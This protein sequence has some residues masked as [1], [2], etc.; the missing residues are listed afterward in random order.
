MSAATENLIPAT[1]LDM[2]EVRI[3]PGWA[4]RIPVSL[5]RRKN[6]LPCCRIGDRVLVACA[7][8]GDVATLDTVERHLEHSIE[9]VQADEDSLEAV[10]R[11]TFGG[12]ATHTGTIRVAAGRGDGD[13]DAVQICEEILQAAALRDASDIHIDPMSQ[14]V[15][16]RL[17]VDGQLEDY[18]EFSSQLHPQISSRIKVLADLDI[19]ERRS[20]QD[21]RFSWTSARGESVDVRVATLPTRFGES[22]TLRLLASNMEDLTLARLGMDEDDLQR[23]STA[24]NRP[25]GLVLLTGPTGSGKSTTLYA[26]LRELISTRALHVVTVEDPVEYEMDGIAQVAVDSADKV[27]F[28]KALRS[29]LR[30]DPDVIM[31]GEIRDAETADIAIKAAL[32]GHLVFSTLHTNTAAGAVTRLID[33]GVQPFLVAATLRLAVAQRLVRQLCPHCRT[34]AKVS[35]S[36]AAALGDPSAQDSPAWNSGV[37]IYCA[38]RGKTGRT[39]LFEMLPVDESMAQLIASGAGEVALHEHANK[40]GCRALAEDALRKVAEGIVTVPDAQG[41]VTVW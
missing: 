13:E 20:P 1:P 5:A 21:G 35:A 34:E 37:C 38:G 29:V 30:N 8:P 12:T 3:D 7:D 33:M 19:S 31:I 28:R 24:I 40:G 17:R 4:L 39:A 9:S 41:A 15:R 36:E 10:I 26:A 32:T 2:S 23:F 16:V 11:D 22:L 6:V 25:Y 18:R 14:Q 27:S